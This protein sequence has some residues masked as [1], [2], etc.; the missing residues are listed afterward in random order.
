LKGEEAL[1]LE[2]RPTGLDQLGQVLGQVHLH[3][4]AL[5]HIVEHVLGVLGPDFGALEGVVH[6][7]VVVHEAGVDLVCV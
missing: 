5:V 6:P 3:G 4:G 2:L 7:P 1:F